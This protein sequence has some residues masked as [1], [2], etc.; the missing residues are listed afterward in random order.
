ML[1]E[2]GDYPEVPAVYQFVGE[3]RLFV[4]AAR[5]LINLYSGFECYIDNNSFVTL[6]LM[7]AQRPVVQT[8]DE[9]T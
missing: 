5:R 6:F 1:L 8:E 7:D 2:L 9:G 4:N 3:F